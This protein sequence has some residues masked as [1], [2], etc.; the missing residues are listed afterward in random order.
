MITMQEHL[1][2]LTDEQRERFLNSSAGN[3][4]KWR[5]AVAIGEKQATGTALI[6]FKGNNVHNL[7]DP[8]F[9]AAGFGEYEVPEHELFSFHVALEARAFHAATGEKL[10]VPRVQKYDK[11]N[12]K[13]VHDNRGFEGKTVF[14][15]HDPTRPLGAEAEAYAREKG[16]IK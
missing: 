5:D 6:T 12:F 8:H 4:I 1:Q 14:I 15:L 10:S 16:W 2:T 11:E 9:L 3:G 13:L 7:K